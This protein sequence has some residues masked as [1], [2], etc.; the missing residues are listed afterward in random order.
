MVR[1]GR[2]LASGGLGA[3]FSRRRAVQLGLGAGAALALPALPHAAPRVGAQQT[4]AADVTGPFDW[5]RHNG[6]TIR[7]L[8]NEHPYQAALVERL[9]AF[10]E[11]TG[12]TVEYDT[13]PESNYFEKLTVDLQS[14]QPSYDVFMLGAYFV[15]QYG[16]PGYLE[17]F[18]P[19]IANESATNSDYDWE[20]IYPNLRQADQWSLE[21]GDPLGTGGQYALPWGFETNTIMYNTEVFQK[22][23]VKPAETLDELV[24]LATTLAEKAPGA[25]YPDMYGIGARG[26][27]QWAT[28]HPGF[29]TMYSRMGGKDFEL[30]DGVL[31]PVMNS[32]VAVDFT[33]TWGQMLRD[34]GPPNWTNYYWYDVGTDLGAQKA[35]MIF[36]A[37][38][39]GYFNNET[40]GGK[41]GWHPGPKGPDGSLLTNQWIWSLGMSSASQNKSAAWHFLQWATGKDHLR[42]A[43]L[44]AE[45]I[46]PVRKSI[47]DDPA[48][49]DRMASQI[50][51]LDTFNAVINETKILFTPQP[52]FFEATT[53]WAEALQDIYGGEDAKETLDTLVADIESTVE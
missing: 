36:D 47:V 45:H 29:M 16:P 22:L 53:L 34:A 10:T 2:S 52:A 21:V 49:V 48:F 51:F 23:G 12:I 3:R 46:D 33:A 6:T 38:I 26:S 9:A 43:A 14:G 18:G 24:E 44:E 15:W 39:L 32:E 41:I 17:D 7:A 40:T 4:G 50:G 20:D 19:W 25:G 13:F 35:A 8:L 27:R 11:L 31:R 30:Q 37:D 1:D 42:A 28:I 5:K